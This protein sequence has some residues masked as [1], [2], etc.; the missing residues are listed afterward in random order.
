MNKEHH[1]GSICRRQSTGNRPIGHANRLTAATATS[2]RTRSTKKTTKAIMTETTL[3]TR[4][5]LETELETVAEDR[6]LRSQIAISRRETRTR[7]AA[8]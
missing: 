5:Q 7:E 4:E 3:P 6:I 1:S 2:R 8:G